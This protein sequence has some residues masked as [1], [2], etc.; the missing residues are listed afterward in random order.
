MSRPSG[1]Q[2]GGML[3]RQG[4]VSE[5]HGGDTL[6][7]QHAFL[8]AIGACHEQLRRKLGLIRVRRNAMR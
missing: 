5:I 7:G 2:A 6:A 3:G 1:D 8:S 4:A